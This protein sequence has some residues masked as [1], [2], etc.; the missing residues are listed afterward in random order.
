MT[1]SR[2]EG[3]ANTNEVTLDI[4]FFALVTNDLRDLRLEWAFL[5]ALLSTTLY[6]E[7]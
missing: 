2:C 3:L 4:E 5:H 7:N 1:A 6:G